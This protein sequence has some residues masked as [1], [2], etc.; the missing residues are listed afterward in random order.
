M[1]KPKSIKKIKYKLKKKK[2][3]FEH[4]KSG[5]TTSRK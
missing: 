2:E 1:I 4:Y 3:K 5:C